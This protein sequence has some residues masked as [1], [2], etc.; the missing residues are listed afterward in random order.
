MPDLKPDPAQLELHLDYLIEWFC[1]AGEHALIELRGLEPNKK[2]PPK[3]K[4]FALDQKAEMIEQCLRWNKQGR[5]VYAGL[6][7]RKPQMPRGKAGDTDD[8]AGGLVQG[9]DCDTLEAVK[10]LHG[11]DDGPP[12]ALVIVTGET[13]TQRAWGLWPLAEIIAPE[14]WTKNQKI[15]AHRFKSDTAITDPPRIHRIA[16]LISYPD[17]GKIGRGYV[18]EIVRIVHDFEDDRE[19]I[20]PQEILRFANGYDPDAATG[21][22]PGSGNGP[23][24]LDAQIAICKA[25]KGGWHAAM[26][27]IL[28]HLFGKG[29]KARRATEFVLKAGAMPAGLDADYAAL[30]AWVVAKQPGIADAQPSPP[31]EGEESDEDAD[32]A[33]AKA[34][35]EEAAVLADLNERHFIVREGSKIVV[36]SPR[37]DP[38]LRRWTIDG[39]G[40]ADFAAM[41]EN[42]V[43]PRV[44]K[45]KNGQKEIT[46]QPWA[47]FWLTHR[48]RRQYLDGVCCDPTNTIAAKGH[49]NLWRGF[50]VEAKAGDW[51]L[52]RRHILEVICSSDQAHF[53]YVMG[54]LSFAVKHPETLPEVALVLCGGRGTGK[55]ILGRALVRIFG[56][57]GIHITNAKHLVGNFNNHLR[58]VIFCFADEA[59]FAGDKTHE[60]VLKG[61]IT[62]PTIGIEAKYRDRIEVPNMIHPLMASNDT[63][64]VPAG[65]DER[66]FAVLKISDARQGDHAYFKA[67]VGQMEGGGYE[68]M[69][70]DLLAH[71]LTGFQI[72]DVPQTKAL[73]DNKASSLTGAPAWLYDV[74]Q[75]GYIDGEPTADTGSRDNRI[76]LYD[77]NPNIT[78]K[79]DAFHDFTKYQRQ[80]R[81]YALPLNLFMR[82]LYAI[83]A[84]AIVRPFK[85]RDGETRTPSVLIAPL[86]DARTHFARFMKSDITWDD[87]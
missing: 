74:L 22:A 33:L 63:W 19:P 50:G 14:H 20:E 75:R 31:E 10:L 47:R 42:R 39:M 35:L 59:F 2:K 6:N 51:T 44:R 84:R 12:P 52:M 54:W 62:E 13:P 69:L 70:H 23:V 76:I 72:R 79:A 56:Q 83:E 32:V 11:L 27:R 68:A 30:L 5:N 1:P 46:Y 53:A 77:Q 67:I 37:Y 57:H 73:M 60:S 41:Y 55:G 16:G 66:R 65:H 86:N 9:A 25:N 28:T 34:A 21:S 45:N 26:T 61:L 8:V 43:V 48:A 7:P 81:S 71:D 78:A 36:Y 87:E 80:Y 64:V 18:A 17:E 24:D 38:I 4:S 15:I 82:D 58:D 3:Y 40:R 49:F 29:W 85:A